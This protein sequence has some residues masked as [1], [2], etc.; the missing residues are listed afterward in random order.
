MM[1]LNKIKYIVSK[2]RSDV[3][4]FLSHFSVCDVLHVCQGAIL[5]IACLLKEYVSRDGVWQLMSSPRPCHDYNNSC[6]SLMQQITSQ[7]GSFRLNI[8]LGPHKDMGELLHGFYHVGGI[9]AGKILGGLYLPSYSSVVVFY[10][11]VAW[12]NG[13]KSSEKYKACIGTFL[14][15]FRSWVFLSNEL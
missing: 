9:C 4:S 14:Y 5:L 1:D 11:W 7:I 12:G 13:R 15:N 2:I 8:L 10:C 6:F 3:W